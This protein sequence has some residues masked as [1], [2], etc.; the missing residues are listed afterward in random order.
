MFVQRLAHDLPALLV[1]LAQTMDQRIVMP[2]GQEQRDDALVVG[3]RVAHHQ[4]AQRARL[5]DQA[6]SDATM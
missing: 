6:L 5:L 2:H 3:R 4:P 1:G